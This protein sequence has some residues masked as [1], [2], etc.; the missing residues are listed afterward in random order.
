M[1]YLVDL[2]TYFWPYLPRYFYFSYRLKSKDVRVWRW[3]MCKIGGSGKMSHLIMMII[4]SPCSKD[5][6]ATNDF[7]SQKPPFTSG[8]FQ[9]CL[10]TPEGFNWP[11]ALIPGKW[12]R[13]ALDFAHWRHCALDPNGPWIPRFSWLRVMI[14]VCI[15]IYDMCVYI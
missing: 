9:P 14:C 4:I 6:H 7:P 11:M 5:K 10:M 13:W 15:Y 3:E 12:S 2:A 8:I 1:A